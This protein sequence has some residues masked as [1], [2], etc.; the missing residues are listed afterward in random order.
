MRDDS[1]LSIAG[2]Q[3]KLLLVR[4]SSGTWA[5]PAGGMPST[6]ILKVEDPRYPGLVEA[7]VAATELAQQLGLTNTNPRLETI[8]SVPCIIVERFDRA[9]V[10]GSVIRLHQEDLCQ[11]LGTDHEANRGRGK[12]Q[13]AGGPSLAQVA[14][15]LGEQAADP[16]GQIALLAKYMTFTVAIGNAD[17]HGKIVGLLHDQTGSTS[18][19]PLYDAVPTVLW[20]NL[21]AE[22]AMSIG[23]AQ[24]LSQVT[25]LDLE[26]EVAQW[27]APARASALAAIDATAAEM[28]SAPV[29]HAGLAGQIAAALA[30]IR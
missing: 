22:P 23:R 29:V 16:I 20:P 14:R 10:N 11:A 3:N 12:Y 6:H 27:P 28:E 26:A 24:T 19:S 1:E 21:R 30:R 18:L 4:D 7:E 9:S 15:L 5:R 2:L 8:G 17:A 25:R 13:S